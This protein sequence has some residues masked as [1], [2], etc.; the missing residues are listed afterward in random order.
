MCGLTRGRTGGHSKFKM[1]LIFK[2][3]FYKEL[4]RKVLII[5]AEGAIGHYFQS[6]AKWKK[7]ENKLKLLPLNHMC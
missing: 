4:F 1:G 3:S 7:N 6:K 5:K 2:F